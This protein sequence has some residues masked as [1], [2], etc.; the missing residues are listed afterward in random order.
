[1][2]YR[3]DQFHPI[4]PSGPPPEEPAAGRTAA[5]QLAEMDYGT[6]REA[7]FIKAVLAYYEGE[8]VSYRARLGAWAAEQLAVLDALPDDHDARAFAS[9][10]QLIVAPKGPDALPELIEAGERMDA[11]RADA[12]NH[13]RANHYAIHAYDHPALAGPGLEVSR[14]CVSIVPGVPHA[15]HMPTHIFTRLGLRDESIALNQRS[16][17]AAIHQSVGEYVSNHCPHAVDYCVNTY[18]QLEQVDQAKEMLVR[19]EQ[20]PNLENNFGTAHA[21]ADAPARIPLEQDDWGAAAQLPRELHTA[22]SW[23]RYP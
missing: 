17:K 6:P 2:G 4:W 21:A 5:A 7:A 8:D 3:D 14:G 23:N 22:V 19:M 9:L 13:P 18:L 11:L 16:G 10:A 12:P 20:Q 1:M 15:L